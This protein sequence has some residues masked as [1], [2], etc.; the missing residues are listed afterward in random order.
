MPRPG[1][2]FAWISY[3][4]HTRSRSLPKASATSA[5]SPRRSK[6]RSS[7][8]SS[9]PSQGTRGGPARRF[10]VNSRGS[11]LHAVETS[12]SSTRSIR[13][14]G[15]CSFIGLLTGG[16][17]IGPDEV[18][19]T[20]RQPPPVRI[21]TPQLPKSQRCNSAQSG[22]PPLTPAASPERPSRRRRPL[23][24]G[25]PEAVATARWHRSTRA[26]PQDLV[27]APP[28]SR[29]LPAATSNLSS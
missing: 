11:P 15:S 8:R 1:N 10:A 27:A 6:S 22:R 16:R 25:V 14:I 7:R 4:W 9:E 18:P 23:V 20:F 2:A 26:G 13:N 29:T 12:G 21:A 28:R 19:K 3:R 17:P 24:A 5:D